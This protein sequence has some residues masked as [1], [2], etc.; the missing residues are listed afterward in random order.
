MNSLI[1]SFKNTCFIALCI[2]LFKTAAHTQTR[3]E[4]TMFQSAFLKNTRSG[5]QFCFTV[6]K[7]TNISYYLLEAGNDSLQTETVAGI[8]PKGNSMLPLQYSYD[9]SALPYSFYR[10]KAVTMNRETFYSITVYRN[11]RE[12]LQEPEKEHIIEMPEAFVFLS[13]Q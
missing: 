8:T 2:C 1:F 9:V 11:C 7:E 5:T 12:K 3:N 10:I 13:L 4:N 6:K